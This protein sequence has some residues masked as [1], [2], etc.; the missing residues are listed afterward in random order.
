MHTLPQL[1]TQED[2]LVTDTLKCFMKG[3]IKHKGHEQSS[4]PRRCTAL[5]HA[6]IAACRPRSFISPLLLAIGIYLHNNN[7]N[8]DIYIAPVS[9]YLLNGA[10]VNNFDKSNSNVIKSGIPTSMRTCQ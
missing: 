1:Y 10:Y 2:G 9:S 8:N 7:N 6:L 5:S 3:V 4:V